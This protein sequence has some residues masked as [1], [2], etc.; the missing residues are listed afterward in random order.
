[1]KKQPLIGIPAG[2]HNGS[3]ILP[4]FSTN[5]HYIEQVAE[6]GAI[7]MILPILPGS[8]RGTLQSM[9]DRCDGFLLP[10]GAD[11]DSEWYGEPLLPGL[12]PDTAALD[13]ESQKTAL[14]FLRMAAASGKPILGICLGMQVLNIALGGTLYQ[15][16]SLQFETDLPHRNPMKA[17]PDRWK[18]AHSVS[19]AEGTLLRS[20]IGTEVSVNSFHHQAVRDLAPGFLPA[21]WAS[22]GLLEGAERE[23]GKVL[24]VQWHPEN[25]AHAGMEE[26]KVFFRWLAEAAC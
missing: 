2:C 15:D 21:A 12:A 3:G 17:L 7:P 24:L 4:L 23:D 11:F 19:T 5:C 10:G 9:V 1:M 26:G 13:F 8:S 20:L 25:L 22:D 14:E 18:L 6:A 16:I